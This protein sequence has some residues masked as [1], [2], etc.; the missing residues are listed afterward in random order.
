LAFLPD[1]FLL[2]RIDTDHRIAT[3]QELGDPLGEVAELRVTVGVL[4]AFQVFGS[5]LQRVA[6]AG[7]Q[8]THR[9]RADRVS[10]GGQRLR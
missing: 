8:P 2:L 6:Q 5:G 9:V 10:C 7:Q 3:G 1:Q 4:A